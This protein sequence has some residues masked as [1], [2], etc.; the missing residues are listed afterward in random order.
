MSLEVG[1][2]FAAVNRMNREGGLWAPL[3]ALGVAAQTCHETGWY[4]HT[5]GVGNF[6]LGGIKCSDNW[7][8]GTIPW[9]TRQC[10]NLWTQEFIK[11]KAGDYKLWF[12]WYDS[13]DTYLLDHARLI[14]L[15]Y[16]VALKNSDCVWGYIAGLHGKWATGPKYF[17][18]VSNMVFRVA[19]ELLGEG[20]DGRLKNAY[21]EAVRR[22][23]LTPS[24]KAFLS[25]RVM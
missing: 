18:S 4:R 2:V 12:R 20:W 24:Q 14:K 17:E 7:R 11:D 19:G 9:S 23:V 8:D 16:P 3:N 21:I 22:N 5:C 15:F 6:N 10:R 1:E 13:L 25:V